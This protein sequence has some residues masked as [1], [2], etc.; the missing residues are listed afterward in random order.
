M[1]PPGMLFPE[2]HW[3]DY[4]DALKEEIQSILLLPPMPAPPI[5]QP[6]QITQPPPVVA[7]AAVPPPATQLPAPL[8]LPMVPMDVQAPQAPSMSAPALYHHGQPI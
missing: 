4:P 3:M 7:Q 2:H 8:P 1:P 6:V 5:S